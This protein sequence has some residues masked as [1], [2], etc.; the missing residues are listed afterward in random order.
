MP[1]MRHPQEKERAMAKPTHYSSKV[2]IPLPSDEAVRQI[3]GQSY[4]SE[5]T[6]NG[7]CHE[8]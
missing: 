2:A 8:N 1:E 3:I 6:L 5:K 4:N 7:G